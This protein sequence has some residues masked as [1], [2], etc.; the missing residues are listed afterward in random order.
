M[1]IWIGK[2][3]FDF[4]SLWWNDLKV[5]VMLAVTDEYEANIDWASLPNLSK[6]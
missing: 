1:G 3:D 4:S 6:L 2:E 5:K